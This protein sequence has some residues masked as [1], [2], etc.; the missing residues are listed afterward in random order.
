MSL[1]KVRFFFKLTKD[2]RYKSGNQ[3]S[4]SKNFALNPHNTCTRAQGNGLF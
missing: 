4:H 1:F 3:L 2:L